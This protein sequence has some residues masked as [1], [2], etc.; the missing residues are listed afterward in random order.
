[1]LD[2][3]KR[4]WSMPINGSDLAARDG[5]LSD[6]VRTRAQSKI[7]QLALNLSSQEYRHCT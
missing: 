3:K 6:Q 1:M 2:E 4:N 5:M 7:G